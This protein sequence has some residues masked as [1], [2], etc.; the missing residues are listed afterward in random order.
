MLYKIEIRSAEDGTLTKRKTYQSLDSLETWLPKMEARYCP[1]G[2]TITVFE[3]LH[4]G[5]SS[6]PHLFK[7]STR[8]N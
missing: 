7:E 4:S 2:N 6:I 8:D 1:I 3:Y 5:W